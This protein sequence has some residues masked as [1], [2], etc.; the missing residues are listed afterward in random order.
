M[1]NFNITYF[2]SIKHASHIISTNQKMISSKVYDASS[3]RIPCNTQRVT[4]NILKDSEKNPEYNKQS[5]LLFVSLN[6]WL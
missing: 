6:L 1:K 4:H 5:F 2:Q 3:A